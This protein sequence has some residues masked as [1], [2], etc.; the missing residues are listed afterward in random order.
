MTP[1]PPY[2]YRFIK[3]G[4]KLRHGDLFWFVDFNQWAPSRL[5]GE[6][7]ENENAYI[8]RSRSKVKPLT[9]RKINLA[10]KQCARHK[11]KAHMLVSMLKKGKG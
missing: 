2:G 8:R 9:R 11:A 10:A 3:A 4:T 5:L 6:R 7:V 1:H